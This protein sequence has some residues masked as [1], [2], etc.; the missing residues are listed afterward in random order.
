MKNSL[1]LVAQTL[2][3]ESNVPDPNH[4]DRLIRRTILFLHPLA[5]LDLGLP[6]VVLLL[7][8]ATIWMLLLAKCL[9]QLLAHGNIRQ[10]SIP[11]RLADTL[12]PGLALSVGSLIRGHIAAH[13]ILTFC[14]LI[15]NRV[16]KSEN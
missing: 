4:E 8:I 10:I 6:P 9:L 16:Q 2:I 14:F 1:W 12:L 5:V 7:A 15:S 11:T 3:I 13:G